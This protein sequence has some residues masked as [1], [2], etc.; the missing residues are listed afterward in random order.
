MSK[1]KA[2]VIL[3]RATLA[4]MVT[5][6]T[7][8]PL[9]CGLDGG[10]TGPP[11]VVGHYTGVNPH[12]GM[13]DYFEL[14]SDGTCQMVPFSIWNTAPYGST[15]SFSSHRTWV[16]H[17]TVYTRRG[18]AAPDVSYSSW[19]TARP[20]S[21]ASLSRRPAVTYDGMSYRS[22]RTGRVVYTSPG[23]T[24]YRSSSYGSRR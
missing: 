16:V 21:P 24:A 10:Y 4:A 12:S 9:A 22:N 2:R 13:P 1:K 8:V 17:S 6:S 14:L 15:L 5:G 11:Y 7:A 20:A 3:A 19:R 23:G 18:S